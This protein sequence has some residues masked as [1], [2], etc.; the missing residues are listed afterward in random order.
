MEKK[1]VKKADKKADRKLIK[2]SDDSELTA[3]GDKFYDIDSEQLIYEVLKDFNHGTIELD[4]VIIKREYLECSKEDVNIL[5][6]EVK[7]KTDAPKATIAIVHGFGQN[8]DLFIEYAI[9]FALNGYKVQTVDLR[10]FG[11]SGGLKATYTL[12]EIQKDIVTLLKEADAELP[13]FFYAHS[14]G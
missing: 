6:T 5:H 14:M 1:G 12:T 10:G 11:W 13:L 3:S 4:D 9:Q 2:L 7:H 8:S